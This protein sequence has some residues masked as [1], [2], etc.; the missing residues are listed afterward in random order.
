MIYTLNGMSMHRILILQF[1]LL[2]PQPI[3][4]NHHIIPSSTHYLSIMRNTYRILINIQHTIVASFWL[5]SALNLYLSSNICPPSN[6]RYT[7]TWS[8]ALQTTRF[9]SSYTVKFYIINL[10]VAIEAAGYG[11]I[12]LWYIFY[13]NV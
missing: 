13:F 1:R 9:F 11:V 10:P 8:L 5:K 7:I 12:F 3:E 4:P 6:D 2:L